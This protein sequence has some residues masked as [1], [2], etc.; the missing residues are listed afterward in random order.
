MAHPAAKSITSVYVFTYVAACVLSRSVVLGEDSEILSTDVC[1]GSQLQLQCPTTGQ[2]LSIV[3]A[4]YGRLSSEVCSEGR[5]AEQVSNTQCRSTSTETVRV[6]TESCEGKESC[7]VMVDHHTLN[8]GVDPCVGTYK[9]LQVQYTCI[10]VSGLEDMEVEPETPAEEE[11]TLC[12]GFNGGVCTVGDEDGQYT[13][14]CA[15]GYLAEINDEEEFNF[16]S[17]EVLNILGDGEWPYTRIGAKW[18]GTWDAGK[19]VFM[20]SGDD[21]TY[22]YTVPGVTL[23]QTEDWC[24]GLGRGYN[25]RNGRWDGLWHMV[26]SGC[27]VRDYAH[28]LCEIPSA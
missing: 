27:S 19:W 24:L 3:D 7:S 13:C 8:A 11:G 20:T 10:A 28:T 25:H 2:T 26:T 14:T 21:A 16:I 6:L 23:Y 4:N 9:Y 17:N 12:R 15:E 5:P 22:I 18:S 1:H